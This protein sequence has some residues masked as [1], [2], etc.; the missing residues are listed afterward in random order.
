[1]AG[2]EGAGGQ[3]GDQAT[4]HFGIKV[5]VEVFDGLLRVAELCLFFAQLQQPRGAPRQ[6]V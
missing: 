2:D 5:E 3:V 1:M 6:F 4:I